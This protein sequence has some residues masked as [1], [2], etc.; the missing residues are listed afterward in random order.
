M[1]G[2]VYLERGIF[3]HPLFT[4]TQ[5][6][7]EREAWIWLFTHANFA[8]GRFRHKSQ[9]YTVPRGGYAT[10]YRALAAS[11]RW[12]PN[13]VI[14]VFQLW[15]SQQ[16][17]ELETERGFV[18]VTIC[19]YESY[20]NRRNAD[21]T[22]PEHPQ[23]TDGT[24]T[25][26]KQRKERKGKEGK[27]TPQSP[28]LPDWIP[29][30]AWQAFKDMRKA[31]RSVMTPRAEQ[32][33][34]TELDR[35]RQKGHDPTELLNNSIRKNWKDIYEPKG[36]SHET[37]RRHTSTTDR[38]ID[39]GY[40]SRD[41]AARAYDECEAIIARRKTAREAAAVGNTFPER[42]AASTGRTDPPALTDLREPEDLRG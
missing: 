18:Q 38:A 2:Y 34:L 39:R 30:D 13:R 31:L 5:P 28:P 4:S 19:N 7:S 24:A 12:S 41:P 37:T 8:E 29:A 11:W 42:F 15:Q 20:Q 27:D 23:N 36:S 9:V 33:I 35:L 21:G 26:T 3:Y 16:M 1:S 14:R 32:L 17:I 25:D 10:S 6:F 40:D 22:L